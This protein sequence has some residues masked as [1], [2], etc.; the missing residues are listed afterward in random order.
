MC[1]LK[2]SN[3]QNRQMIEKIHFLIDVSSS[4]K[5]IIETVCESITST[6]EP[7]PDETVISLSTFSND[8]SIDRLETPKSMFSKPN[9][10]TGGKTALYDSIVELVSHEM[11]RQEEKHLTLVIITDGINTHGTKTY[12]DANESIN[13]IK[14]KNVTI[15]FLGA[16]QNAIATASILG[17][18]EG[19]ALTYS[20][21][22]FHVAE[23]FRGLSEVMIR[24]I[25]TGEEQHF[26]LP[27]RT[28][29]AGPTDFAQEQ[30]YYSL[31]PLIRRASNINPFTTT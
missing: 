5:D 16:N 19:D 15:K 21:D 30:E 12:I 2:A 3:S 26:S 6:I 13:E 17:V 22:T 23:A 11:Q 27:Q 28:A 25:Q 8:V 31:P 20:A 10:S 24:R 1:S 7:L 29:S 14:A 9:L 4:M 18:D